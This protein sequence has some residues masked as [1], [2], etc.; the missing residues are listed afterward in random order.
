MTAEEKKNYSNWEPVFDRNADA[1]GK[2]D[3]VLAVISYELPSSQQLVLKTTE[4]V[5]PACREADLYAGTKEVVVNLPDNG[6]VWEMGYARA[7]NQPVIGYHPQEIPKNLNLMLS[8]GCNYLVCGE[9]NLQ[10]MIEM[11]AHDR[12]TAMKK[13]DAKVMFTGDVI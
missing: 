2:S 8:H 7:L 3:Y 12:Y 10:E 9:A 11:I 4:T 1:I 5:I 13:F 6:T